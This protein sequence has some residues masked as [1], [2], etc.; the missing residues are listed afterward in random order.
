[1]ETPAEDGVPPEHEYD[2]IADV[3]REAHIQSSC[4]HRLIADF[5]EAIG[6]RAALDVQPTDITRWVRRA[7]PRIEPPR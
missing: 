7:V 3:L 2:W 1:M 5:C 4:R 6:Q